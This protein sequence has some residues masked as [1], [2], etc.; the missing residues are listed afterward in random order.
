[1]KSLPSPSHW[2]FRSLVEATGQFRKH[3]QLST[4]SYFLS[5][6]ADSGCSKHVKRLC[7]FLFPNPAAMRALASVIGERSNCSSEVRIRYKRVSAPCCLVQ[8]NKLPPKS[9]FT[10]STKTPNSYA[11]TL[12]ALSGTLSEFGGIVVCNRKDFLLDAC[13]VIPESKE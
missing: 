2:E 12:P 10:Q 11:L 4:L 8:N 9:D 7:P 6:R 3:Q 5:A 1:M 13:H